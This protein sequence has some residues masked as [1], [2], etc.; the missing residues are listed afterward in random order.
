METSKER[1][2]DQKD[3]IDA[4]CLKAANP[5]DEQSMDVDFVDYLSDKKYY[6]EKFDYNAY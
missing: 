6:Q 5:E 3:S 4:H 1:K 2:K